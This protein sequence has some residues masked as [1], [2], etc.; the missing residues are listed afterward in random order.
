MP[1]VEVATS[2][3]GLVQFLVALAK[4]N[5]VDCQAD[6]ALRAELNR[7]CGDRASIKYERDTAPRRSG[8][9]RRAV[10]R[11]TCFSLLAERAKGDSPLIGDCEDL[12]AIWGAYLLLSG[13]RVAVCMR[14]HYPLV[15]GWPQ[16][17]TVNT[18]ASHQ[19]PVVAHCRDWLTGRLADWLTGDCV[20]YRLSRSRISL[21]NS[22]SGFGVSGGAGAAA[23]SAAIRAFM[24]LTMRTTMNTANARISVFTSTVTNWP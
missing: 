15:A 13:F 23:S 8:K 21:N 7:R 20:I 22:T 14:A 24:L 18:V 16:G 19:S 12:T 17:K 3:R 4:T 10:D 1:F 6:T 2:V 5:V 9:G 11:W